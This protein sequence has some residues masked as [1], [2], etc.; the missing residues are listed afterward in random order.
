MTKQEALPLKWP[1]RYGHDTFVVAECNKA[2]FDTVIN[3]EEWP[4][5]I[6]MLIGDNASGKTHLAKIFQEHHH[7]FWIGNAADIETALQQNPPFIVV[8]DAHR[9]END[10]ALFHLFNN[11]LTRKARLLLTAPS[12]SST[13]I[14]LPDLLSR[15]KAS[16]YVMLNN[17]DEPMIK[18]AYQKL[19][20]DRG[21]FVDEK[22]L[23]Y[24]SIRTERSFAGVVKNVDILDKAALRNKKK[25]TIPLIN[26]SG[27][28]EQT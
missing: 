16:H 10:E 1:Q 9:I 28:F 14:H 20:N 23:D 19:F 12:E 24:L 27:L 5:P 26:D 2:G 8:D 17:P 4:I 18:A 13:W 11:I 7:A 22:V 21:L 3:P 15:L 25:V 6:T